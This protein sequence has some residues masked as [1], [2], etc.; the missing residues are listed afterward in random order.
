MRRVYAGSEREWV[1]SGGSRTG[2]AQGPAIDALHSARCNR[3]KDG[4][5]VFLPSPGYTR[6][7]A[8]TP[9]ARLHVP[10]S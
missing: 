4:G 8:R 6:T 10:R 5:L 2:K 9:Q 7:P 1:V 3:A